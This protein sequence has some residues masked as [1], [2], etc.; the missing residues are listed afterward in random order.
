VNPLPPDG[1]SRLRISIVTGFFLPV[2]AVSGGATEKIWHGMARIFAS[3]G[4]SVTFI[5]RRWPGLADE[6]TVDGIHHLRL[7]GFDH[8]RRLSLNLARDLVWGVRVAQAL[9]RADAVICNTVTLPVWL[10]FLKPSAGKVSV[11]IGRTP[12]GQVGFYRGVARIYAPSSYVAGLIRSKW[13]SLRTR[14]TGYPIDWPLHAQASR[15]SGNPVTVGFVGRLHPE[16]GIGLLVRAASKLAARKG[17]PAWRLVLVGPSGTNEGGGGGEWIDALRGESKRA[18][19]DR[20]EWLAPEFDP[21]RLATLYGGM[22]VF[23]YPSLA[24]KGETFGVAVAEAMAAGCAVVV[25]ALACFGDLVDDGKTGLVFDH[26]S[27]DADQRLADCLCRLIV[28]TETRRRL[29]ASG[30]QHVRRFGYP[31]V[32]RKILEDLA[33]LSGAGAEKRP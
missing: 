14:V 19:G 20:V 30:Q 25:S 1:S 3:A 8:T 27:P 33:L 4:H 24:I 18:L 17:L 11:M 6:E 28:E 10:R 22:D 16:K 13:A 7:P 26:A 5:S 9:P 31:E 2:P 15:Q 32:S 23:C 21:E 29:A 12:K